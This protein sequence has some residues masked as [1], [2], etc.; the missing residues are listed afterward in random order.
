MSNKPTT[1][2]EPAEITRLTDLRKREVQAL[3]AALS[4]RDWHATEMA[5]SQLRD[6]LDRLL[7]ERRAANPP[8]TE[9]EQW[10]R[11]ER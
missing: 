5:Y 1:A 6:K 2:W 11:M 7:I 8:L 4:R 10:Q 3:G 9:Y